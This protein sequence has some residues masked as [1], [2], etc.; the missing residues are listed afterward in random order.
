MMYVRNMTLLHYEIC[1]H[2]DVEFIVMSFNLHMW[3]A[4]HAVAFYEPL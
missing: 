2:D 4:L 1:T 3:K